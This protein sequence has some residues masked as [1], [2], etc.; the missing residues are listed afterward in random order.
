MALCACGEG[1]DPGVHTRPSAQPR[2]LALA[3]LERLLRSPPSGQAASEQ[4]SREE[5]RGA[6]EQLQDIAAL[7]PSHLHV[8]QL[9]LS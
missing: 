3:A 6:A 2:D 7:P 8:S 9:L 1:D 5:W 4:R